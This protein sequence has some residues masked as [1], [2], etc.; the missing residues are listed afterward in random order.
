MSRYEGDDAEP[1]LEPDGPLVET[2]IV[3]GNGSV[4]DGS[5]C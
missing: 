5:G 4:C 3:P 2:V 1:M